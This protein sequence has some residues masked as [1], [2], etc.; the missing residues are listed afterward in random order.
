MLA[1]RTLACRYQA[2]SAE[3]ETLTTEPE[4]LTAAAAA[5]PTHNHLR[6]GAGPSMLTSLGISCGC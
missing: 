5:P 6:T 2:L 3:I 1:P 4:R